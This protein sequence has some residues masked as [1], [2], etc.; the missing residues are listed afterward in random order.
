MSLLDDIDIVRE[1]EGVKHGG[2]GPTSFWWLRAEDRRGVHEWVDDGE[3]QI[4]PRPPIGGG[5]S[6]EPG[7]P[8]PAGPAGPRGERGEA[9]PIGPIGPPGPQGEAAT[10]AVV[11]TT[12]GQPGTDAKVWNVGTPQ[13]AQL[14]FTIPRGEP[15]ET[16]DTDD[17]E[18]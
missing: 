5:G 11:L 12:T 13:D 7:P 14:K 18:Y 8:G 6:G 10:V 16:G 15:G 9:G 3:I 17:G 2:F 1:R 4:G